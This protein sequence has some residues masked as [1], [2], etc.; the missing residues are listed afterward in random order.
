MKGSG[1]KTLDLKEP[2]MAFFYGYCSTATMKFLGNHF[3]MTVY[4]SA[5]ILST[6]LNNVRGMED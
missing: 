3:K 2:F 6:H 4:F 1:Q 5:G